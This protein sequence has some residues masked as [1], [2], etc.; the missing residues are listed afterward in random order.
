MHCKYN[1]FASMRSKGDQMSTSLQ[2]YTSLAGRI[3][4]ALI[5]I[6]SGI[7]KIG[8]FDGTA[9]YMSSNGMPM[10]SI[11]LIG[12]IV[13]ELAGGLS[14]LVGYKTRYGVL[15]LL[16]FLIPATLVF[17]AFWAVPEDMV[18]MQTIAFLKNIAIMGGLLTVLSHGPGRL[19]V[20][21][22]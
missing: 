20:D 7:G 3:F 22:E 5:F 9:A 8:N 19:S 4:L 13:F 14:L 10:V 21:K 16:V 2:D 17:H 11:L 6:M 15:M 12:A 1:D 18:K